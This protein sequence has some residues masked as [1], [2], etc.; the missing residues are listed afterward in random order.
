MIRRIGSRIV[1]SLAVAVGLAV[2]YGWASL[3]GVHV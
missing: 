1:V 2:I 3:L